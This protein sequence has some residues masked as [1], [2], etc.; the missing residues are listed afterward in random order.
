MTISIDVVIDVAGEAAGSPGIAREFAYSK[1]SPAPPLVTLS[2]ADTTGVTSYQWSIIG[3][4]DGASAILSSVTAASPTFT[5]TA[6]VAATYIVECIVNSGEAYARNALAFS[7]QYLGLRKPAPGETIQFGSSFGWEEALSEVIEAI[8]L[9]T[10]SFRIRTVI[11]YV[12]CTAAPP[13]EVMGDRYILDQTVGAVHADWDGA[14]KLDVVEFNG[15]VWEAFTPSEGWI[16]YVDLKDMDY[17][18]IDDGVPDWEPA[19]HAGSLDQAY[20]NLGAGAGR[21]ITADSGPVEITVPDTTNDVGLKVINNDDTNDPSA[22]EIENNT[23]SGTSIEFTGS[24]DGRIIGTNR[25][26]SFSASNSSGSK[27]TAS[28]GADGSGAGDV[29]AILLALA[30][31]AG[32]ADVEII[33]TSIGAGAAGV[34]ISADDLIDI[35]AG[36]ALSINSSGGVINIG[37][38]AD[39]QNINMGTGAAARTITIGNATGATAVDLKSGTG[40]INLNDGVA[41]LDLDGAGAL[42]ENSLVSADITPSGALTLRGGGVSQ[43][44]DDTGY[45][46]FGGTGALSTSGITTVDLDCS[47]ALSINSSGGVLNIGND[48]DAQNIN[49]GTGAAARTITIGNATGAT[50]VDILS[51]TGGINLNDGIAQLDL[52]GAGALTETSLVS[53]DITPSGALTLRGGGVSQFGDDTGYFAFGGTGA[54]STSGITTIDLDCS[55]ALS[56]NSSG[57]VINI[58]NDADAQNINIGT[59]AAARTITV[60]NATG[61]TGVAINTGSGGLVVTSGGILTLGGTT[62]CTLTGSSVSINSSASNIDIGTNALA[63]SV[64]IG[65]GAGAKAVTVGSLTTTSSL[66]LLAGTGLMSFADGYKAGSTYSSDLVLSDSSAEWSNF[67]TLFGEVSLVNAV[68]QAMSVVNTGFG[69]NIDSAATTVQDVFDE[70]DREASEREWDGSFVNSSH[71]IAS[72]RGQAQDV[73]SVSLFGSFVTSGT[74]NLTPDGTSGTELDLANDAAYTGKGIIQA[75]RADMTS[76]TPLVK[77]WEVSFT[78]FND[79][80]TLRLI[81]SDVNELHST[82]NG[83]ESDWEVYLDLNQTDEELEIIGK[84]STSVGTGYTL[85]FQGGFRIEKL[86]TS[87]LVGP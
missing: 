2:L 83:N 7:T 64:N 87:L 30:T 74:C 52:D 36:T 85:A 6:N 28:L 17:R 29:S 65:T 86:D 66:A 10:G 45:F 27:Y 42:T 50:A 5:P 21:S 24:G 84:S 46:D 70:Y 73:F 32:D 49:I 31:G 78:V 19:P 61:A 15:S 47:G 53:A 40:G 25:D 43:F 68:N 14:A 35:D 60:G 57:G 55:G 77:S 81:G 44:G 75:A 16:G 72:T 48:A 12:D 11:D 51:G 20:D 67:E 82:N 26:V 54:L 80:G 8:D 37:N 71:K 63:Q 79:G 18:Y 22:L 62:A 9:T 1:V 58:G 3:Q 56:L 4:T 39:A 38:D 76:G 41:Q 33:A 59:G 69:G 23:S 34:S 13:T